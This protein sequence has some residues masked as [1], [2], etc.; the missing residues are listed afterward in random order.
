MLPEN[1]KPGASHELRPQGWTEFED[2][3]NKTHPNFFSRL[4]KKYQDLSQQELHICAMIRVGM[5]SCE[6]AERLVVPERTIENH[7]T[8]IRK[9]ANLTNTKQKLSTF[10]MRF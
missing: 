4:S 8:N 7:R 1:E 6:I 10:L 5:A 2:A 9:K 3:F